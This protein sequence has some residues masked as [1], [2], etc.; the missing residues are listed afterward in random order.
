[1]KTALQIVIWRALMESAFLSFLV[2]EFLGQRL[3]TSERV[4]A[5]ES[6]R[7]SSQRQPPLPVSIIDAM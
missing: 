5:I 6:T 3:T 7:L 4:D 1:M 2:R